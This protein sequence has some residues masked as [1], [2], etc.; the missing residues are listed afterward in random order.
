MSLRPAKV[1]GT[2]SNPESPRGPSFVTWLTVR[3]YTLMAC[4]VITGLSGPE[5]CSTKPSQCQY[6]SNSH[7]LKMIYTNHNTKA[8]TWDTSGSV[9]IP[10]FHLKATFTHI[11]FTKYMQ[12]P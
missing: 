8:Y 3:P 7:T 5:P 9:S 1:A 6:V 10:R 2:N 11:C 4:I 12:Y